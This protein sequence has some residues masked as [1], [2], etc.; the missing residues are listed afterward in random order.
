MQIDHVFVMCDVGAPE[1]EALLRLGLREGPRNIH[2]GQ[3][4]SCRR[5]PFHDAYLEL[6]WVHDE[7]EASNHAVAPTQLRERWS[8]RRSGACPFGI[9]LSGQGDDDT[10]VPEWPAWPYRP[11]YLSPGEAIALPHDSP[12]NE[13]LIAYAGFLR[14]RPRLRAGTD[15]HLLPP[16]SLTRLRIDLPDAGPLS[17]ATRRL[18]DDGLIEVIASEHHLLRLGFDGETTGAS[19]DLR[20]DLPVI[21]AW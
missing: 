21:L 10:P 4:T 17:A 20:P 3:G 11:S 13:P 1:S 9:V 8:M 2:P 16:G 6:L 14:H 15:A 19:A 12:L 5:F 18:R 7:T